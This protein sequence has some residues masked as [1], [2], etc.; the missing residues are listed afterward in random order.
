MNGRRRT[1]RRSVWLA[2]AAALGAA[3]VVSPDVASA[4]QFT[5]TV[6]SNPRGVRVPPVYE[7][8]KR[9]VTIPAVYDPATTYPTTS[10]CTSDRIV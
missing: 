4:G 7:T 5:L 8:R 6:G 1:S 9:V 10:G 2:C 3:W